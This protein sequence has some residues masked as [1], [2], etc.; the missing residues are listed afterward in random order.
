MAI[1]DDPLDWLGNWNTFQLEASPAMAYFSSAP[2]QGKTSAALSSPMQRQYWG[3]QYGNVINQ[4]QGAMGSA[5][6]TGTEAPSFVDFLQDMPWTE[7]YTALS[8]SLRP[9]SSF[10]RF[11]PQTRYIY[12]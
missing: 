6:R 12:Q 4:Y 1:N 7:R 10:G 3:G 11:S 5:L 9:G 2:F 8:P